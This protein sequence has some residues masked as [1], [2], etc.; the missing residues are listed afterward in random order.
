[1][2]LEITK[3]ALHPHSNKAI[4]TRNALF[5]MNHRVIRSKWHYTQNKIQINKKQVFEFIYN[6]SLCKNL[7]NLERKKLYESINKVE[8]II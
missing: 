2:E 4:F 3:K 1:M 5:I 6:H 7:V 8:V